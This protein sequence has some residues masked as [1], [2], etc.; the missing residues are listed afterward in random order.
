[1]I[2][3]IGIFGFVVYL[4]RYLNK[5]IQELEKKVICPSQYTIMIQNLPKDFE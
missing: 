3:A 2:T 4:K 5:D 1:M